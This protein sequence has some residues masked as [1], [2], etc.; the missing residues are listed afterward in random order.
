[1]SNDIIVEGLIERKI[2][3]IRGQKAML[4][5]EIAMLY[6]VETRILIQAIKRNRDRF[7]DDFMFQLTKEELEILRSQFVISSW[8]GRRYLP[9]VFTQ[10]GIAMLS[11]ILNS[12]RA[13][14][15]N[16]TIMRAFIKLRQVL[17]HNKDLAD[18][19]KELEVRVGKNDQ[20]IAVIFEAIKRL[21]TPEEK[22]KKKI[23]FHAD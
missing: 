5:S 18:K 13:V 20:Q 14:K 9:Y 10:E 17:A 6:G 12:L 19:F 8:G 23:G 16:I 3:L 4:D 21:M 22:P 7:P 1:M 15:V 2:Y 11:G